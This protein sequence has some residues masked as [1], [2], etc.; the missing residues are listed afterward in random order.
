M[1]TATRVD[2]MSSVFKAVVTTS[3][4]IF[5][6]FDV[7]FFEETLSYTYAFVVFIFLELVLVVVMLNTLIAILG[8]S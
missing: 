1:A 6:D 8:E 5:G 4:I 2:N 7:N 3:R